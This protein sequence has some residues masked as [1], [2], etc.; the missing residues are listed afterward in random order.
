LARKRRFGTDGSARKPKK[1]WRRLMLEKI[2]NALVNLSS[3]I[4][5]GKI[6]SSDHPSS[7][8]F[9]LRTYRSLHESLT[10]KEEIIIGIVKDELAWEGEIFF[11]LSE[12]LKPLIRYLQE[13]DIER[14]IFLPNLQEEE[15]S[16]FVC[17]LIDKEKKGTADAQEYLSALGVRNIRV[18]KIRAFSTQSEIAGTPRKS[19]K[20]QEKT[21]QGV[22]QLIEKVLNEEDLD[23]VELKFNVLTYMEDYMGRRQEL[24]DLVS[25]KQKDLTTFLHLLNVSILS[26]YVS[27]KLGYS[28]DDVLDLG[29]SG[30]FHDIGKLAISRRILQKKSRLEEKEFS[31]IKLHPSAG[32][33]ILVNYADTLGLLPVVVAYEHHLR[34]DLKGYPFLAY[35]Y[36][37]HY[38]S[39]IISLCDVY[40][41][42]TLRRSY[43]KDFPPKKIY[44]IMMDGKGSM[45][46]PQLIEDFFRVMGVWP[47]GTIVSLSNR[48]IAVVRAINEQDLFR[49]TVEVIHPEKKREMIDLADTKVKLSIKKSLNPFKE[50]KKYLEFIRDNT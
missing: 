47:L 46:H 34:Y 17:F 15:L 12:K 14:M 44:N 10:Q 8:E 31:K 16:R 26:M 22:S 39:L 20:K 50:G 28:Q 19:R 42:L 41:A 4:Q 1:F 49:P 18:G 32:A 36:E 30:L 35:P 40:D 13:K 3:A 21:I 6:Y 45:F 11:S 27:S 43:K 37:P 7:K 24:F 2:K 48:S 29:I 33:E 5:A 25:I 9:T 23:Y 38:A